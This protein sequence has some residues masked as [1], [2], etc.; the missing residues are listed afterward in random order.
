VRLYGKRRVSGWDVGGH[1]CRAV[2][3]SGVHEVRRQAR[4]MRI[5]LSD[6]SAVALKTDI[7]ADVQEVR[8]GPH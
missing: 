6:A 3:V 8:V 7:G 1:P 2:A 5:G 4:Y